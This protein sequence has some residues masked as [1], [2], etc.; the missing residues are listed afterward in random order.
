MSVQVMLYYSNSQ[1]T[2][3]NTYLL[4]GHEWMV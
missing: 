3:E 4:Q 2:F 1:V